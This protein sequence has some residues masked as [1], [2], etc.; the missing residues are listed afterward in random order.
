MSRRQFLAKLA[1]AT[2]AAAFMSVAGPAIDKAYPAGPCSGHLSDI[3]HFVLL[4]QENRSF[5]SY[6]GTLSGVNGF[7]GASPAFQQKGG[8]PA[9]QAKD[10][11]GI[12]VPYRFDTTRGPLLDDECVNDPVRRIATPGC[13][14]RS[15]SGCTTSSG[16]WRPGWSRAAR[17]RNHP[18]TAPGPQRC[19]RPRPRSARTASRWSMR[20]TAICSRGHGIRGRSGR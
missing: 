11:S 6:F 14:R 17:Y 3:E 18:E 15:W 8:N 9:T 4:M 12:T 20:H 7:D 19:R 13:D 16:R 1:A 2:G 5:D 10:P